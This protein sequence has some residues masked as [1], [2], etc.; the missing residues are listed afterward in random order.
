[1]ASP[2][3]APHISNEGCK[4]PHTAGRSGLPKMRQRLY[5][6]NK[7]QRTPAGLPCGMPGIGEE[8]EGAMQQAPQPARQVNT[9]GLFIGSMVSNL[10]FAALNFLVIFYS[11]RFSLYRRQQINFWHRS[12]LPALRFSFADTI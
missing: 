5:S 8:M 11:N 9:L 10:V 7:I 4:L 6:T 2:L 1:M 12:I 3:F